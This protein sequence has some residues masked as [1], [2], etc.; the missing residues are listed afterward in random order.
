MATAGSKVLANDFPT[1]V[2]STDTTAIA[3]ITS[4]TAIPGSPEVGVAFIAPTSGQVAI[5]VA[6]G[7]RDNGGTNRIFVSTEVYTGSSAAGTKITSASVSLNG[8]STPP[9]NT[10]G[11][12][13]AG[14]TWLQTGL[15]A[16]STY[17]A[18]VV[19]YVDAGTTADLTMRGIVVTPTT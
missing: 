6:M 7:G 1:A 4:T 12:T 18:R 5:H 19:Y 13:Y 9:I 3:N 17:Y 10:A 16:G 11:Y 15:T 14:R 2:A 8:V